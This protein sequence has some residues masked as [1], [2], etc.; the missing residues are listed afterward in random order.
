LPEATAELK[1]LGKFDAAAA[2]AEDGGEEGASGL[3]VA[4][5]TLWSG[6]RRL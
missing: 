3:R 1:R 5:A 2:V 4:L 6:T